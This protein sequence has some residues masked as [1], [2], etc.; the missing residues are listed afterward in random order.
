M[1]NNMND[2]FDQEIKAYKKLRRALLE[3]RQLSEQEKHWMLN[4]ILKS[5]DHH[6]LMIELELH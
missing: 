3:D 6:Q 2:V 4:H 5:I 1:A